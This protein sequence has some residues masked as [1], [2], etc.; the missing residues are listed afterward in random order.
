MNYK[1][2][3]HGNNRDQMQRNVYSGNRGTA[4]PY[5]KNSYFSSLFPSINSK[6]ALTAIK[7]TVV[8]LSV[9]IL[10]V[11]NIATA[12]IGNVLEK[13]NYIP[14]NE[15]YDSSYYDDYTVSVSD[16]QSNADVPPPKEEIKS[17][18]QILADNYGASLDEDGL[19]YKDGVKNILLLGSDSRYKLK[20][21]WNCNTDVMIIASIDSNNHKITLSSIMRDIYVYIPGRNKYDKLNSACAYNGGP[22]RTVKVIEDNFGVKIDNFVI[23]SFYSFIDIVEALGGVTVDIDKGEQEWINNYIREFNQNSGNG[24]ETGL[25]LKTGKDI[26]LTGKQA[27]GYVRVRF[28]GNGDYERTERQ[29]EVLEQLIQSARNA[30]YLKLIQLINDVAN[31]I[32]TDFTSDELI[33]FAAS[34]VNYLDYDIEQFRVPVEGTYEGHFVTKEMWALEIDFEPNRE[35]LLKTIFGNE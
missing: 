17:Q 14:E 9:L 31:Y 22:G 20:K 8:I 6:R 28:S 12:T 33:S 1:Q 16:I 7:Y 15:M 23:V 34:A 21:K 5:N 10:L 24:I 11:I 3:Y 25:L 18:I 27:M 30:S 2:P 29:R 19:M 26:H 4:N 35:A 13:I 32:S